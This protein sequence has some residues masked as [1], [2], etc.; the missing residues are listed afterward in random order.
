M[1]VKKSSFMK[2]LVDAEG[3][4]KIGERDVQTDVLKTPSPSVNWAFGTRGHGLPKGFSLILYGPPKGG[5][6]LLCNA[7]IGEL[8]K[9]DP[10]A[11]AV[12]FN[13]EL[14][15]EAQ[16]NK[17]GCKTWGIDPDRLAILDRNQPD[18]IFDF[19]VKDIN[20]ACNSG[21]KIKLIVIDSLTA[22]AGRRFLNSDSINQQQ[23]GDAAAT[24]Q[25]G[26]LMIL[27]VIRRHKITLIMTTHIRAEMDQ[28]EIMRGNTV[29][30]AGAFASK[31]M[32]EFFAFVEPNQSKT[33][34]T[35]L[36]GEEFVDQETKDFMDKAERTGHK[37]RFTMKQTSFGKGVGRTGEF[38]LDY[39]R[40]I[41]N[42]YE[43]VFTLAK[44]SGVIEKPNNVTYKYKER[45]WRGLPAILKAL[46]DEPLL[47][48]E[49]L[50]DVYEHDANSTRA[51]RP[52]GDIAEV[53]E[54][55]TQDSDAEV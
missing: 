6:S 42:T 47:Y 55:Q 25:Q 53:T 9:E 12:Y 24:I 51:E 54:G 52:A 32:A 30:M 7:I 46:R 45:S 48:N 18:G 20:D 16:S 15:G 23:I 40:G 22:I 29:K 34:K 5:K 26:L 4:V 44:N 11:V 36:G 31:H 8:H 14:R 41:I 37:I 33:G 43:E 38:T 27:P 49:V 50:K 1:A 39:E 21:E 13:T 35:S 10:E 28:K 19:I 3:F 17:D 2:K